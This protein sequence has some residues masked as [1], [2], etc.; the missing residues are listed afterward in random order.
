MK[1]FFAPA[2]LAATLL[3][4]LAP[5][6][7]IDSVTPSDGAI[8]TIITLTGT[9][10]DAKKLKPVF[11][12]D[13]EIV[14]KT[15]LRVVKGSESPTTMQVEVKKTV[16][17]TFT[18]GF[19]DKQ[20]V[21]GE[22]TDTFSA[23]PPQPL[24]VT[25]STASIGQSVEVRVDDLGTKRT[26]AYIGG[27]KAKITDAGEPDEDGV[28]TITVE[29][30]KKIAAGTWPLVVVNP[31][32]EGILKNAITVPNGDGTVPTKKI[33]TKIELTGLKKFKPK[34]TQ[35]DIDPTSFDVGALA[36][37]KKKPRALAVT[38]PVLP[39]D[40]E[41]GDSFTADPAQIVYTE[42]NKNETT[43][44][45]TQPGGGW[46]IDVVSI[47][48]DEIVLALCGKLAR[49]NGT[50]GPEETCILGFVVSPTTEPPLPEG[51]CE[52]EATTT[53]STT[54]NFVFDDHGAAAWVPVTQTTAF[55]VGNWAPG[56]PGEA[57]V[58]GMQ[59]T[60][61]Y[62]PNTQGAAT[63]NQILGANTLSGFSLFLSDGTTWTASIDPKTLTTS[64][65][66]TIT[67]NVLLS[68]PS[69]SVRGS[70]YGTVE[71]VVQR[72]IDGQLVT[73]TISA[74]FC[75][76]WGFGDGT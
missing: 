7:T 27:K 4:P 37:S 36:G 43:A 49:V 8:G 34:I 26:F 40:V 52:P 17:G 21:A 18:I 5:A 38:I 23:N 11:V 72:P 58:E 2:A 33:D 61:S 19:K 59:W 50:Q 63:L 57:L 10:L 13:G 62:D 39:E 29:V 69:G 20:D 73:Q 15:K 71:G 22:S 51:Q 45:Q 66:V 55:A 12:Q 16:A 76:P 54:G 75:L 64:V 35:I 32:G 48:D 53:T 28:T 56:A 67:D 24:D 74:T 25:P 68:Q 44:W 41:A 14:K 30:P 47:T 1:S 42:E 3:V 9:D 31:L 70:L 60:S 65:T 46:A 6:Q